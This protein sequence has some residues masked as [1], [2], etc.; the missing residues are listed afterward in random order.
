MDW[1]DMTECG[2]ILADHPG[3]WACYILVLDTSLGPAVKLY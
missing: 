2:R 3:I 1:V